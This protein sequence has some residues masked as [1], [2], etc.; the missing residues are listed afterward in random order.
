MPF[1]RPSLKELIERIAADLEG[2]LPGSDARL[3]RR[4][5]TI[6]GRT[7]AGATHGLHG[8]QAYLAE[9][10]HPDTAALEYLERFASLY[11]LT[12]K[13]ASKAVGNLS[14][15]GTDASVVP[16]GTLLQRSDGAEFTTAADTTIVAASASV[17]ATASLGGLAGDTAAASTL[18]LVN[19]IPGIEGA[20]TV[21]VGGLS[22]GTDQ[23]SDAD[24]RDRL[25]ARIRQPPH[26]GAAFD[27]ENWALEVPGVTRAWCFPLNRGTG[28]IDL[29]FV[30]DDQV[31]SIIPDAAKVAEVQTHIDALRP[32]TADFLALAPT[33]IP[34]NFTI[35]TNPATQVVTDAVQAELEDL[36]RREA[37]PEDGAGS[38]TILLSHIREAISIAAGETD[39]T[40][41]SPA[42]DV[43]FAAGQIATMGAIT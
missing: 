9:Q 31:G 12:R 15:T 8:H 30:C 3:R 26:G 18:N 32:V 25:L 6:L 4:L 42:A 41:T 13:A 36:L 40:L 2:Q 39:H 29:Y 28:T 20:V 35:Q 38:G 43:T 16:A 24:L 7:L 27:Y 19:P 23:E 5:L 22:D 14:F 21:A 17:S 10:I 11:G 37:Q 34:V 33:A 1:N